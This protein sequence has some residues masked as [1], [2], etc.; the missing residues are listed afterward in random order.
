M[1][2]ELR[3]AVEGEVYGDME[4][5]VAAVEA[6]LT[7]LAADPAA[8]RRLVAWDWIQD[9]LTALPVHSRAMSD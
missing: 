1:L 6:K 2:E 9:A 3:R 7:D 4:R 8:V 5:K